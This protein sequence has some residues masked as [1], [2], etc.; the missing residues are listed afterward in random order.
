[1]SEG[2]DYAEGPQAA[3][4]ARVIREDVEPG[5]AVGVKV[6]EGSP[7]HI[8]VLVHFSDDDVEGLRDLGEERRREYVDGMIEALDAE[9][10][11]DGCSVGVGIRGRIFYGAIGVRRLGQETEYDLSAVAQT[12]ALDALFTPSAAPAAAPQAPAPAAPGR[13]AS[14]LEQLNELCGDVWCEGEN[15]YRFIALDCD[16]Q[17]CRLDIEVR[18]YDAAIDGLGPPASHTLDLGRVT[19]VEDSAGSGSEQL[20]QAVS[21]AI[22]R[23][24]GQ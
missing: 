4:I 16:D 11:S 24:E 6:I 3:A 21:D 15:D 1:M 18:R 22:A 19:P 13:Y 2:E 12:D 17:R 10:F 23:F 20:E 5:D 14:V 7:P 8:V 9:G